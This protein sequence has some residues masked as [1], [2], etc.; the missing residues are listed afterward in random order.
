LPTPRQDLFHP[1]GLWF[2]KRKKIWHFCLR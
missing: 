1:S 2:C